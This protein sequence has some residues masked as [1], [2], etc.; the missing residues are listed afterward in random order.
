MSK[1]ESEA[2]E[3]LEKIK[4]L[5]EYGGENC[6]KDVKIYR[7]EIDTIYKKTKTNDK[8]IIQGL[9]EEAKKFCD[10]IEEREQ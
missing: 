1:H 10:E 8:P 5:H 7:N 6:F 2:R 3:W 9:R 4:R